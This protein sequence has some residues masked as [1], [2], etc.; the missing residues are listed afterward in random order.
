[1]S[2]DKKIALN[3]K[4]TVKCNNVKK[5]FQLVRSE[6]VDSTFSKISNESPL[7]KLLLGSKAKEVIKVKTPNGITEYKIVSIES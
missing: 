2:K 4:V 1:M 5:T 6:S 3:S 7:G